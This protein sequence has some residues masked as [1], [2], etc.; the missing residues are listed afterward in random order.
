MKMINGALPAAI[1]LTAAL[2]GPA[3]WG[4]VSSDMPEEGP[5]PVAK[6]PASVVNTARRTCPGV[7]LNKAEF[8]WLSDDGMFIIEGHCGGDNVRM[9]VTGTGRLD[10]FAVL[11]DD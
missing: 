7:L 3:A 6:V 11:E 9:S 8:R 4:Q 10:H 5:I 1:A 2:I